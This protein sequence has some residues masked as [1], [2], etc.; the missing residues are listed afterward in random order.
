MGILKNVMFTLLAI[1]CLVLA[2]CN[3]EV[4][5]SS[6]SNEGQETNSADKENTLS[7]KE[8]QA[9]LLDFINGDI[10][11]VSSFEVEAFQSFSSVSGENYINDE[12]MYE[13][14]TS[15]TVPAYEKALEETEKLEAPFP[16][17]EPLLEQIKTASNAFYEALLLQKQ[18]LEEQDE[19]IMNQ[20]NEKLLEYSDLIGAYHEDMKAL[21]NEY[22]IDYEPN[23][24]Q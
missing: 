13:E 9:A 12:L 10:A 22:N 24:F 18:A 23:G 17:M 3:Y 14:L 8:K 6:N 5:V 7:E 4:K 20:A 21:T 16:E 11:K 15:T 2:G 1:C 19:E